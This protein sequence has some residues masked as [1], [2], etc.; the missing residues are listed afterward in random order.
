M[1]RRAVST[2]THTADSGMSDAALGAIY[3]R[4]ELVP[5]VGIEPTRIAPE[6]F[7]STASANS[8]TRAWVQRPRKL[9]N[10]VR[11]VH[12]KFLPPVLNVVRPHRVSP[13][14]KL[15]VLFRKVHS[16]QS[17]SAGAL[18]VILAPLLFSGAARVRRARVFPTLEH[19]ASER[20]PPKPVVE[21]VLPRLR[22]PVQ[23]R[24]Y[25]RLPRLRPAR[26]S[27]AR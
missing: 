7:E 26:H 6:D 16:L 14:V 3:L 8:A 22:F 21:S 2:D 5:G 13:S 25:V 9:G 4:Q 20:P 1:P 11:H 18:G 15:P 17:K 27:G 19:P 10:R 23:R 12:V 24:T